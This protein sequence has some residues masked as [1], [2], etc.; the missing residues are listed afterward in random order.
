MSS[1]EPS[2]QIGNDIPTV[3]DRCRKLAKLKIQP[4][5]DPADNSFNEVELIKRYVPEAAIK[6][7]KK[8]NQK[9]ESLEESSAGN[10]IYCPECYYHIVNWNFQSKNPINLYGLRDFIKTIFFTIL[11]Y[12]FFFILFAILILHGDAPF[13]NSNLIE[14]YL[15]FSII[16]EV[17][18]LV[19]WQININHKKQN[20]FKKYGEPSIKNLALE[21][22]D[23]YPVDAIITNC[24]TCRSEIKITDVTCPNPYCGVNK[25][26]FKDKDFRLITFFGDRS[27]FFL[28]SKDKNKE[29]LNGKHNGV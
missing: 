7:S 15:F 19:L 8:K 22:F 5:F 25:E 26:D 11:F 9:S 4:R 29:T 23:T 10:T 14:N 1:N 6:L 28:R 12:P 3:C 16:F 24:A 13:F 21:L 2:N 27:L 17:S 20:Y 18:L